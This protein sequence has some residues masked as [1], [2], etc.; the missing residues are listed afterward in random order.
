MSCKNF[1]CS[2]TQVDTMFKRAEQYIDDQIADRTY[3][4]S[5]YWVD[6]F[7][8]KPFPDGA[9][10]TL[11]KMRFYGDIGPQYDGFDGWRVVEI[12][13]NIGSAFQPAQGG[14]GYD[15]QEVGHG[16][17]TVSYDLMQRD[18]RTKP[19][20]VKD[21]RTFFQYQQVQD[22]IFKN[23]AQISANQ[24]EQLNRNAAL[25]YAV[26][27][28]AIPGLPFN[29]ANPYV[30]PNISGV[31]DIGRLSTRML[32]SAY[33]PLAEEAG[34]FALARLDGMP[35]FGLVGHPETLADMIYD[36]PEIR[37]D[38]RWDQSNV[39]NL[40][41]R[42]NFTEQIFGMYM[43]MPDIHA[44]RF[45][46]DSA[47]NLIRVF[48]YERDVQIEIGT[49]PVVNPRYQNAPYEFV[50]VIGRDMFALRTRKPLTSVGG[51]TNFD[52]ETGIFQWKWHNPERC[53]DPYR[54][55]GRYVT[56]AE[57]GVEP[58]DFTDYP[59]FLVKRRPQ[60]NEITY[61]GPADCPPEEGE[62]VLPV[63]G[64]QG[65]PCPRINEVFP[66]TTDD[67]LLFVFDRVIDQGVGQEVLV[68]LANG[69][70]VAGTIETKNGR[71]VT[72]S[73]GIPVEA[74]PDTFI[75]I[76]CQPVSACDSKVNGCTDCGSAVTNVANLFL[77]RAIICAEVTTP[78]A[79][80]VQAYFG[81]GT[82]AIMNV[83]TWSP[84]ELKLGVRYATGYGPTWDPD[85]SEPLSTYDLIC[86]RKGVKRICC[87]PTEANGCPACD[88]ADT[89]CSAVCNLTTAQTLAGTVLVTSVTVNGD[90]TAAPGSLELQ[91]TA[92]VL[93][94][95]N[96]LDVD[97]TW[98]YTYTGGVAT[99]TLT[100]APQGTEI[101]VRIA[102]TNYTM[103][104]SGCTTTPG[105]D[106][107]CVGCG[108]DVE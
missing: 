7:P 100:G 84:G 56:T 21:I 34:Q 67:E 59:G 88:T 44:P 96:T 55:I 39:A 20:C 36:D 31:S 18:L 82:D 95:L 32:R 51:Q 79:Q 9:G 90:V 8:V 78:T 12:T 91:D 93:T 45:E 40:L 13:R 19:I 66:T 89:E 14:C 41:K 4:M 25:N 86:D 57:V 50:Q 54:R 98:T 101:V 28:I 70:P 49:R 73:F 97:G 64:S 105:E 3:E 60:G 6:L 1:S 16:M 27:H 106:E 74:T 63:L 38:I 94:F 15:W 85:G 48:P 43:L 37:K 75:G 69:A 62:C 99:F 83:I 23:L 30:L 107:S 46:A 108:D 5:R 65:C 35:T 42:Y 47:G 72:V 71:K 33:F 52:A 11:D 80:Q 81:D 58:G 77:E 26:K 61:W 87:V 102:S 76:A 17:E 92:D 29:S 103:T 10:L 24:R 2:P 104:S 53:E 68:E 22:L